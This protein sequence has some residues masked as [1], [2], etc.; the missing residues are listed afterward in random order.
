MSIFLN[1][2]PEILE[3]NIE[4]GEAQEK[5]FYKY[6]IV[7]N[8][9]LEGTRLHGDIRMNLNEMCWKANISAF[10]HRS[11]YTI[12]D[13]T[14]ENLPL[15]PESVTLGNNKAAKIYDFR[16]DILELGDPP[17]TITLEN[18]SMFCFL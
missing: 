8:S 10:Q 1:S 17:F 9:H 16:I 15:I 7:I 12:N 5:Y 2:S 18:I 11:I 13:I 14:F 3:H 6:M 4:W